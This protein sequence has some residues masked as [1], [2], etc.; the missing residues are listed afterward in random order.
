MLTFTHY[1]KFRK[2]PL[3]SLIIFST[4][5]ALYCYSSQR[6]KMFIFTRQ[7]EFCFVHFTI[8]TR[9]NTTVYVKIPCSRYYILEW[10]P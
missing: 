3:L 5:D 9:S 7:L 8:S 6:I 1:I 4:C 10:N 2:E